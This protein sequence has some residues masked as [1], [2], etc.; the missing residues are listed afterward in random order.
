MIQPLFSLWCWS[1]CPSSKSS[2]FGFE[3]EN[4]YPRCFRSANSTSGLCGSKNCWPMLCLVIGI[5][6]PISNLGTI[7]RI[8]P[9]FADSKIEG[10]NSTHIQNYYTLAIKSA[11]ISAPIF[12]SKLLQLANWL[13]AS[14]SKLDRIIGTEICAHFLA[15]PL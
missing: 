15:S 2:K 9:N 11:C 8:Y 6:Y 14:S 13:L 12:P 1:K 5:S 10:E 3:C 4:L 7:N